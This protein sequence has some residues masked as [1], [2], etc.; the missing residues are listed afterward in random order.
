VRHELLAFFCLLSIPV[1]A[2]ELPKVEIFGGYSF[3]SVGEKDLTSRQSLNGWEASVSGNLTKWFAVEGDVSG[4]YMSQSVDGVSGT[5]S[6]YTFACGPRV[7]FKPLFAQVLVGG[8]RVS[9]SAF[10]FNASHDG[11]SVAA[12]GGLQWSFSPR[13]SARA[14]ADYVMNRHNIS[15]PGVSTTVTLNNVRA[16]VG[17]VYSFGGMAR[18]APHSVAPRASHSAATR[19]PALGIE[20]DT[21]EQNAGARVV[22]VTPGGAGDRAGLRVDDVIRRVDGKPI[23]SAQELAAELAGRELGSRALVHYVRRYWESDATATL[24]QPR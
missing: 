13:L 9:A 18:S 16:S 24:E 19:I 12:G 3:L 7:N 17:I 5:V 2:Q 10:G 15:V 20:V 8:D 22:A 14:S 1:A 4:H 23:G 6:D 11:L 21:L